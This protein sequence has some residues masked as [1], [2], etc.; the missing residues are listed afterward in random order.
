MTTMRLRREDKII[1]TGMIMEGAGLFLDILQHLN[2]GI[3]TEEGLLTPFHFVILLGFLLTAVGVAIL[4]LKR[5]SG[6]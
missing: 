3:E 1:L 2:I 6:R 5:T 4:L